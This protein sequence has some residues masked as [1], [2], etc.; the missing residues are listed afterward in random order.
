MNRRKRSDGMTRRQF[1]KKTGIGIGAVAL[2]QSS[3]AES[4]Q[5]PKGISKE[6]HDVVV[7][8]TGLSG[9]LAAL[10]A[11]MNGADV[12][13]LEKTNINNSG[14]SSKLAAGM[15]AIPNDN[16]KQAKD[17]Y[18]EDF[19]KKS[20]GKA[21][22][23][24]TRVLADQVFDGVD[25]LKTQGIEFTPPIPT[26]GFR[27][28]GMVVAPGLYKGM[29]KALERLREVLEKQGTKIAYETKAKELIMDSRGK[30]V[31]VKAIDN[32]GVKDYISQA[33]IIASGGFSANKEMLQLWV[34][35]DADAMMARGVPWSTGDGI[36]MAHKAGALL[37]NMGGMTSLHVAAVSPKNTAAGNPFIFLP[38]CVGINREGKRFADESKGYVALGKITMKQPGQKVALIF[39]EELKKTP[40]GTA[41]VKLFQGLGIEVIETET[42]EQLASKIGAPPAALKLTIDEFNNA[43]KDGKALGIKPPKEALANKIITPKFYAFY[44]LVPG[45][46]LTFG[47][48]KVNPN[49]QV[50]EPDG[51]VIPG[52]YSV[53]E[54]VGGIFYDD[55]IGGGSLAR[56]VVLGRIAGKNAA[57]QKI[58]KKKTS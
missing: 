19:I 26:P 52:L 18:Y 20:M 54:C 13:I 5:L 6:K 36:K 28:K 21:D 57:S 50:L 58:S 31:G 47:G 23:E 9:L 12:V 25:W 24:L 32:V 40:V 7:I 48:V 27:V 38:F 46:T 8:G 30:V 17:D 56:C 45:I 41:T 22:P 1:I 33:V 14:G 42:I 53:G 11:R 4:S 34:D 37:V 55:Y 15:I 43:V 3:L 49:A 35:P 39:D 44:P 16:T 29:P 10:E 51:R 2:G